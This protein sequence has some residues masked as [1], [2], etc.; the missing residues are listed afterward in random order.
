M[1]FYLFVYETL[2]VVNLV[3]LQYALHVYTH[4]MCKNLDCSYIPQLCNKSV[5][6]AL[7]LHSQPSTNNFKPIALVMGG[8]SHDKL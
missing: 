1:A 3:V 7:K 8:T 2:A 4:C 5:D 6:T